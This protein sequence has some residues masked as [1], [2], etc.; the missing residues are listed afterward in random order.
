MSKKIVF[1]DAILNTKSA[2]VQLLRH[3]GI[4]RDFA[5]TNMPELRAMVKMYSSEQKFAAVKAIMEAEGETFVR[6]DFELEIDDDGVQER[7]HHEERLPSQDVADESQG[8][9]RRPAHQEQEHRSI[10]NNDA[11]PRPQGL[12]NEAAPEV[13]EVA[14]MLAKLLSSGKQQPIDAHAVAEIA[15]TTFNER[16]GVLKDAIRNMLESFKG[17][18][19]TDIDEG[20]KTIKPRE[21]V[22]KTERSEVKIDGLQHFKFE[23]LLK[24]CSAVKP[25][26]N[27][28]NLWLYGP[29]GT[30]KTSAAVNIAKALGLPFYTTGALLTK[31]DITGFIDANGKLIRSPFREAWEN[32]GIYLFDEIDGSA[33]AALVAFNAALANGVMAF[34]D[35]MIQR[36]PDCVVIAAAN[37]SGLGA[38][39]EFTGRMKID[40]ATLDRFTVMQWPIDEAIETA[41]ASNKQWLRTVLYVRKAVSDKGIKGVC[42]TPRA[43]IDGCALLNAGLDMDDVKSM[44]LRK[45]MSPEQWAMVAPAF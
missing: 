1:D 5:R 44:V 43:T 13:N 37:T 19:K 40:M 17:E 4:R 12:Q 38:T 39:A 32:G 33:P 7:D 31:Y 18:V 22:I 45:A 14:A 21:I 26:G 36:H 30:G 6:A 20:L 11:P 41:L 25:D 27:R 2:C 10:E 23:A 16:A 28:L 35:G 15:S 9:P 3:F 29:P 24:A 42:I 34:P 8:E